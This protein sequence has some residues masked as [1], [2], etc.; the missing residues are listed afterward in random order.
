MYEI[1]MTGVGR[2]ALG[3]IKSTDFGYLS[4]MGVMPN[5]GICRSWVRKGILHLLNG[6]PSGRFFL[7][8]YVKVSEDQ[9]MLWEL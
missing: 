6:F 7:V 8:K 9:G 3:P 4:C 5:F 2:E 1:S